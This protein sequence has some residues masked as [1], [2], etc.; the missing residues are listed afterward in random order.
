MVY[1]G[2]RLSWGD[3]AGDKPGDEAKLGNTAKL[4]TSLG[5]RLKHGNTAKLETSLGMRL[6]WG[7]QL[8]WRQAWGRG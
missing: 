4:E 6:S 3:E 7:I 2:T 1:V 5:T 8:S